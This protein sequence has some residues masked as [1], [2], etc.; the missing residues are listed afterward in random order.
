MEEV[1]ILPAQKNAPNS[2]KRTNRSVQI[3]RI[4]VA[5]YCRVSTD[6][7]EQLGSFNSQKLYYE[8]KISNN[9]EWV[10]AGIFADEAI[11]G[12]K[13]DKREGFQ[14]MIQKC[15]AGEI[16]MIITKSISRF[17]RNT[18]DTLKYVRMLRNKNIAVYFEKENINTLD[19]NGEML[20][21]IL[22]SLAQQEVESLSENVKMGIRMKMQRGELVGFNGC[23]GFD[24]DRETKSI[25]V[26]EKEAEVVR[27]MYD[28]YLQGY[29]TTTIARRLTELGCK[30]KHG[31]VKWQTDTI[32]DIIK[33]EK[34][35]GDLLLGK[36][37]TVDPITK[38]RLDNMGEEN[39]YY[40]RDHHEAIVSREVWEKAKEIRLSRAKSKWKMSSENRQRYTRLYAFSSM[41][42]CGYCGYKL[43]RRTRHQTT[44]TKKPVW[45]CINASKNGIC[46]CPNS[47]AIDESILESAF[48]DAFHVL[49]D[50]FD[51]VKET[52]I[53]TVESSLNDDGDVKR[54]KHLNKEISSIKTKKSRL[55]ELLIDDRI[56]QGEYDQKKIEFQR[57]LHQLSEEKQYLE[58]NVG[59]RKN[60]SK[61][62][63][64]L[65]ETLE[66]EKDPLTEFDRMVFD[67][68]TEKVIV[69][70]YDADNNPAP[71][72]L[73]FIFKCDKNIRVKD[74]KSDYKQKHPKKGN[75]VK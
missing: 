63:S 15:M 2:L 31:E 9:K 19:M 74:A 10:S 16:D 34:H 23:F 38:R 48:I 1:Q 5:A 46:N 17:S 43:A 28:L 21:T 47:K 67:S 52:V 57:K 37:F 11:T 41:L 69:G 62:M 42:E 32:L 27:L 56:E 3:D 39:Q 14:Q 18:A 13:V 73:K 36:T 70:G 29:G 60:I 71:Y 22:S 66:T 30:N 24:Y 55:T 54:I 58:D 40:I 33:N 6:G 44:V 7:D 64:E 8:E 26:N 45:Q 65:R 61:R 35:C 25:S 50:N 68:I 20:L 72:N 49:A 53:E 75:V 12:T 59:R 51:D 4:R